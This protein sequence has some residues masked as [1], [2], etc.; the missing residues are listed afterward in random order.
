MTW[1]T[2]SSVHLDS[3]QRFI[4]AEIRSRHS[5]ST[6]WPAANAWVFIAQMVEHYC[7]NAE[8]MDLNP[9]KVPKSAGGLFAIA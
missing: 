4:E 1:N 5:S 7:I 8:A 9:V 3:M 6:N 2:K